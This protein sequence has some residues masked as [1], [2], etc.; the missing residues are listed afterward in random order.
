MI[1]TPVV[2][3]D[4]WEWMWAPYDA[5]IYQL[6][7]DQIDVE[8]IILEIGA[9]DLRLSRQMAERVKKVYALEQNQALL[10]RSSR[11]LPANIQVITGDART[12]P[13]PK[14]ITTAVLLMRHCRHFSLYFEKLQAS[15]CQRLITN[16]R[17]GM[18]VETINLRGSR[19]PYQSLEMGW[20]ACRCGNCGFK[21][22]PA[23]ALSEAIAE[24][25]WE[26]DSCPLCTAVAN[27]TIHCFTNE[28]STSI[29][30]PAW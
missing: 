19:R 7:L 21:P 3:V 22:G 27:M 6:V 18:N 15:D 1:R 12:I 24:H 28:P 25:A 23:E 14:E 20:Y 4:A 2:P 29:K 16:A 30:E 13:F 5:S 8:D 26:V 9:G 17:W 11:A 10:E